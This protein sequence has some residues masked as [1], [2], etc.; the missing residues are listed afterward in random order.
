MEIRLAE[1]SVKI[2]PTEL[3]QTTH[4]A[5]RIKRIIPFLSCQENPF[6]N[7]TRKIGFIMNE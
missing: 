5:A 6:L 2:K 1:A 4:Q 7:G 3:L